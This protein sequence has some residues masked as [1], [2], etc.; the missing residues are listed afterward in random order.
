MH[1]CLRNL[2]LKVRNCENEYIRI[3]DG[4]ITELEGKHQLYL[5]AGGG[6][7]IV[8]E[9]E[10][11]VI[12]YGKNKVITGE[13]YKTAMFDMKKNTEINK[14]KRDAVKGSVKFVKRNDAGKVQERIIKPKEENPA[15][16]LE[17]LLDSFQARGR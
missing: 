15:K 6:Y 4:Q 5:Y 8:D 16:E 13:E 11:P 17:K 10:Q 9:Y 14:K 3:Y 2:L 7:Y 12:E 1:P